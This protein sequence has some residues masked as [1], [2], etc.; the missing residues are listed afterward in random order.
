MN[1]KKL[2]FVVTEGNILGFIV[3]RDGMIID[4]GRTYAIAKI[5]LQSLKKAKQYFLGKINFVRR[6]VPNFA[7][8]VRPLQDLI[9]KDDL[10]KWYETKKDAS[11]NIWKAIMDAPILMS[12]YFDKDFILYTFAIDFS[13]DVVL[14]QKQAE[15]SEIPISFMRSTFKGVE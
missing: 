3:S 11:I 12:P 6:F 2:I 14:T 10:F 9:K 4:S 7:Q 8:I 5:G 15:D 13:Y 1:I